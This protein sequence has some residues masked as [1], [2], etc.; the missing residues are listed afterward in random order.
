MGNGFLIS[1]WNDI[2]WG[3]HGLSTVFPRLFRL[4]NQKNAVIADVLSLSLCGHSWNL[5]FNRD[6][7][8][9][10]I[11]LLEPLESNLENVF[12]SKSFLDKR[13]WT[14]ESSRTFT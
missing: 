12:I 4:S 6:L 14:L 5:T 1:F 7:F 13:V 3:D 9:W 2:W 11:D 8:D 10:E